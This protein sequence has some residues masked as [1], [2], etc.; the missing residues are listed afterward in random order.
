MR[1]NYLAPVLALLGLLSIGIIPHG[2]TAQEESPWTDFRTRSSY[3]AEELGAALFPGAAPPVRTRGV[4]M[5]SPQSPPAVLLKKASVIIPV[6]FETNSA[7][8]LSQYYADLDKLG[9]QL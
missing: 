9:A 8:I 4:Q 2:L 1:R 6:L 5:R 3:T 7:M